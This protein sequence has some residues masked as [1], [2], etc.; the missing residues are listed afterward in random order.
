[1]SAASTRASR[2]ASVSDP[3]G[4]WG[5]PTTT[6]VTACASSSARSCRM[7]KRLPARRGRVASGWGGGRGSAERA[8]PMRR[9]RESV[10]E[11]KRGELGGG[12]IIKKKKEIGELVVT[13]SKKSE[14]KEKS[15]WDE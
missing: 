8:R 5:N 13:I 10:G 1:M 4:A 15:R 3:S 12:R 7:G 11:G 9:D 2:A 6:P 14:K